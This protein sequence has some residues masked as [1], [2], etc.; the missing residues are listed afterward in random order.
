MKHLVAGLI[1]V[2]STVASANAN[3][4]ICFPLFE[5]AENRFDTIFSDTQ[6]HY[7][8]M[9]LNSSIDGVKH[10]YIKQEVSKRCSTDDFKHEHHGEVTS[11]WCADD[12]FFVI[13]FGMKRRGNEQC[14]TY[15]VTVP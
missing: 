4:M 5:R 1:L 14:L 13:R 9:L 2:I 6:R 10:D 11:V 3:E 7:K 8:N 12:D 15:I